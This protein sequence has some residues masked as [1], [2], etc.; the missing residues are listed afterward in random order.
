MCAQKPRLG[1]KGSLKGTIVVF[2]SK[3]WHT[4]LTFMCMQRCKQRWAYNFY[5]QLRLVICDAKLLVEFA[6]FAS[7]WPLVVLSVVI[8]IKEKVIQVNCRAL[9]SQILNMNWKTPCNWRDPLSKCTSFPSAQ[10]HLI[11]LRAWNAGHCQHITRHR[12]YREC[13]E[14]KAL[15]GGVSH[16]VGTQPSLAP[17]TT[18]APSKVPSVLSPPSQ[19][20]LCPPTIVL[21]PLPSIPFPPWCRPPYTSFFYSPQ[22]SF[23]SMVRVF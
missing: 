20:A 23:L 16:T 21:H 17:C 2:A 4:Y 9:L 5:V 7:C 22:L 13:A 15:A 11:H 8:L 1:I 6:S 3:G 12:V 10:V 19:S 14:K 18:P